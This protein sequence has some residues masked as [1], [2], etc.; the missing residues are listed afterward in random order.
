MLVMT[1][2]IGERVFVPELKLVLTVISIKGGIVRFG[3]TAPPEIKILREE[4]QMEAR[5]KLK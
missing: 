3:F 4:I 5:K 2:K 1:R